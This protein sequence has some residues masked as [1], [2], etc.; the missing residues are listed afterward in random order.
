M[1]V[2]AVL[3][4][5]KNLVVEQG[6]YDSHKGLLKTKRHNYIVDEK[7]FFF[8]KTR[9]GKLKTYVFIDVNA[10]KSLSKDQ[11][12]GKSVSPQLR[13]TLDAEL[14]NKLDYLIEASFWESLNLRKKDLLLIGI[15]M[16]AGMGILQLIRIVLAMY[17]YYIP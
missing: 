16:L 6:K 2:K 11:I 10:H 3:L 15:S 17:G 1:K 8:S 7:D 5:G 12:H 4:Q 9:L 14:Q 13:K